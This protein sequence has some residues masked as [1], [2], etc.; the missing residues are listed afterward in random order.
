MLHLHYL[1]FK[2]HSFKSYWNIYDLMLLLVSV[3]FKN[4]QLCNPFPPEIKTWTAYFTTALTIPGEGGVNII[5]KHVLAVSLCTISK[6]CHL[7]LLIHYQRTTVS[8][9]TNL[10]KRQPSTSM[11]LHYSITAR[12]LGQW[13]L[14]ACHHIT[15]SDNLPHYHCQSL[16]H[17]S[18]PFI[19]HH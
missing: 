15:L 16:S 4:I 7:S 11:L 17:Q 5:W 14:P 9:K 6:D 8:D 13:P 2:W 19:K 18:D 10:S 1:W 3:A 12:C